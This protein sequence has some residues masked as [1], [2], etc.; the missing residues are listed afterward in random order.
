MNPVESLY[1]WI[2]SAL[3]QGDEQRVPIRVD[4]PN[5]YYLI[6]GTDVQLDYT[7]SST[8]DLPAGSDAVI[9]IETDY[10]VLETDPT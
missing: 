6:E 3:R 5:G 8:H 10:D 9:V 4:A 1:R 7:L 2:L